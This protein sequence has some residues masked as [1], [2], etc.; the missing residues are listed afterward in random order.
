LPGRVLGL[1]VCRGAGARWS[2]AWA[3]G[4][5]GVGAEVARVGASPWHGPAGSGREG[6]FLAARVGREQGRR[7][8]R[9]GSGCARREVRI[10][11][12]RWRLP[13]LGLMGF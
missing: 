3:S 4:V 10:S 9:G 5:A 6:E 1:L 11:R 12:G 7:E 8:Q 2:W 13:L